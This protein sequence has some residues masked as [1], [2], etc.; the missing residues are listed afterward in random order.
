MI[1]KTRKKRLRKEITEAEKALYYAFK[2]LREETKEQVAKLDG[3]PD[4]SEGEKKICDDLKKALKIS[5]KFIGKEIKNIEQE[6]K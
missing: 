4:L 5:E 6:I 1:G 3:K 2:A